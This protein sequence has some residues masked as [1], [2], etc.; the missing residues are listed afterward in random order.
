M[1][2]VYYI[3]LLMVIVSCKTDT[4]YLNLDTIELNTSESK[5]I[6]EYN[7]LFDTS[8]YELIPLSDTKIPIGNVTKIQIVDSLLFLLD[9]H[10]KSIHIFSCNGNH[11]YTVSR[12]GRSSSEYLNITDFF[13]TNSN[14]FILDQDLMKI[15]VLNTNGTFCKNID[16]SKCW[17]NNLFVING[18]IYLSNNN[19]K[20]DLGQYR[21][22][23]I[24]MDGECKEKFL[25]FKTRYKTNSEK[26]YSILNNNEILYCNSPINIIY[27]ITNDSIIPTYKID[28]GKQNLPPQ[29]WTYNLR[30][31]RE[32][33]LESKFIYGIDRIYE[34][35][36]FIFLKY[37]FNRNKYL[38]IY[39]KQTKTTELICKGIIVKDMYHIGLSNFHIQD[40][41][42]YDIN[43]ADDFITLYNE[44]IKNKSNINE[45][46]RTEINDVISKINIDSNPIIVK[47]KI[48]EK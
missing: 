38:A 6:I 14:I 48:R 9:S 21:L 5:E 27:R 24:N 13:V 26:C 39:N 11:K 34:T 4:E 3:I 43:S 8:E 36:N 29:Y 32:N 37:F 30:E 20:T 19:S 41:Y 12:I 47:Y 16:I 15:L 40:G 18:T 10:T 45:K 2:N 7:E 33:D 1:K 46:C 35:T 23:K 44:I 22:F 28:F 17:A 42:I 25:H 31:Y